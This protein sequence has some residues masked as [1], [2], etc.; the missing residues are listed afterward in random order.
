MSYTSQMRQTPT[1]VFK[2]ETHLFCTISASIA[3]SPQRYMTLSPYSDHCEKAPRAVLLRVPVLV[4]SYIHGQVHRG[5]PCFDLVGSHAIAAVAAIP[6]VRIASASWLAKTTILDS[7]AQGH[8]ASWAPCI[9]TVLIP[10]QVPPGPISH[11]INLKESAPKTN[12]FFSL[13]TQVV[14]F[15]MVYFC[16]TRVGRMWVFYIKPAHFSAT[17]TP[18]ASKEDVARGIRRWSGLAKSHASI[19]CQGGLS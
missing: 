2:E 10:T 5:K 3:G 11:W 6:F 7:L 17:C 9:E 8:I 18:L 1:N 12:T 14:G 19:V 16:L 15:A 4:S 13:A